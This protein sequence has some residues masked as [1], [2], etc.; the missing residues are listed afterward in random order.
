MRSGI[1][2]C[3]CSRIIF[4]LA[5]ASW[6]S[7][8]SR[9]RCWLVW[10]RVDNRFSRLVRYVLDNITSGPALCCNCF[11]AIYSNFLQH[12][13]DFTCFRLHSAVLYCIV[14]HTQK[15]K[16]YSESVTTL[17]TDTETVTTAR[18][19][20][21]GSAAKGLKGS[22]NPFSSMICRIHF[23]CPF[24]QMFGAKTWLCVNIGS[25][26]RVRIKSADGKN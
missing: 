25:V 24:A 10:G 12:W 19:S 15:E 26:G 16:K 21:K 5:R 20:S 17:Q 11:T 13:S 2:C 22:W 18:R 6:A 23:L 3:M 1:K 4:Y 7:L 8:D 14:P 9:P